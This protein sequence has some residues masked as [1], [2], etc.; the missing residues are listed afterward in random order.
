MQD[1]WTYMLRCSDGSYYVGHTD[2]IDARIGQHQDGSL[3]GYT[4]TRR[5]VSRVWSDRFLD[6][7]SAFAA[8]RQI[9]GWSR[10]KK[11]ALIRG[12]WSEISTLARR[13]GLL[14]DG[15][16]PSTSSVSPPPQDE[17]ERKKS[18]RGE[19]GPSPSR[20][21]FATPLRGPKSRCPSSEEEG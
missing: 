3:G 19:E 7:E 4:S 17:R 18:A 11:E 1:F 8:E 9:K 13:R 5:P 10:A 14:R 15:D 2:D 12:D 21:V 6:R 20:R 16:E